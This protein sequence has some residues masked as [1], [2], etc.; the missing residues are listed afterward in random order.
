MTGQWSLMRSRAPAHPT[1]CW[2]TGQAVTDF[3]PE[4]AQLRQ[5]RFGQFSGSGGD[6][7]IDNHGQEFSNSMG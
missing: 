6:E 4:G 3:L 1:G 2:A 5:G 7:T